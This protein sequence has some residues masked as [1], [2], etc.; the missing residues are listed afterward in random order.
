M[1]QVSTVIDVWNSFATFG[2]ATMN[3]VKVM[4]SARSPARRAPRTHQG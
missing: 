3:T 2:R 1:V 4:F